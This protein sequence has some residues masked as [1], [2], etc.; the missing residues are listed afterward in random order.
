[1]RLGPGV[2]LFRVLSETE[3]AVNRRRLADY[4]S[5]AIW[6]DMSKS[7]SVSRRMAPLTD[8]P[9]DTEF[10][11]AILEKL[12]TINELTSRTLARIFT[13]HSRPHG[14]RQGMHKDYDGALIDALASGSV[15]PASLLLAVQEQEDT[16]LWVR[17]T[18]RHVPV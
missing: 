18:R 17:G 8:D 12:A 14:R 1:M 13:L 3:A 11:L 15:L 4:K 7:F 5:K 6:N 2:I 10:K 9:A 16:H